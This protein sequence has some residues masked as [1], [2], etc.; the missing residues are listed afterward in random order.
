ME[1]KLDSWMENDGTRTMALQGVVY[2]NG[3]VPICGL[4]VEMVS[5]SS[6]IH[7]SSGGCN[8]SSGWSVFIEGSPPL[9]NVCLSD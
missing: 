9:L 7:S 8:C 2:N 1:E 4:K 6:T 3:T 5:C